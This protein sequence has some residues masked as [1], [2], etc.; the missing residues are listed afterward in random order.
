MRIMVIAIDERILTG[1]KGTWEAERNLLGNTG[2][3]RS[4][5]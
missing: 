3:F 1:K 2:S 4:T 5:L